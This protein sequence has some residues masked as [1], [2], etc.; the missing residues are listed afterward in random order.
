MNWLDIFTLFVGGMGV[1]A[2]AALWVVYTTYPETDLK[3]GRRVK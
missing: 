3:T 1:G 2:L